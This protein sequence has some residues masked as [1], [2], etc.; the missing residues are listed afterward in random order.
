[1]LQIKRSTIGAAIIALILTLV[2]AAVGLAMWNE[3]LIV[4]GNVDTGN[5]DAE[6]TFESAIDN[7]ETHDVAQCSATTSDLSDAAPLG[8]GGPSNK[9]SITVKNGYPG[10]ECWVRFGVYNNGSIPVLVSQPDFTKLPPA[11]A[12]TVSLEDCYTEN[13]F[14][15]RNESVSCTVK[16]LVEQG[17]VQGQSYQFEA[18]VEARQ[19]NE[20]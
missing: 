10:Y 9:L 14:L 13:T 17:A 3:T 4:E 1:M 18:N 20:P 15:A 16:V 11:D 5:V 19:F 2:S 6:V 12:L 7:E 8:G